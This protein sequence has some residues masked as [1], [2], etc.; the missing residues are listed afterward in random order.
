MSAERIM[1]DSATPAAVI[2]AVK[3]G[4]KFDGLPISLA[5]LY[6]DGLYAASAADWAALQAAGIDPRSLVGITVFG[7]GGEAMRAATGDAEPGDMDPAHVA[8]WALAEHKAGHYPVPYC[9]RSWKPKV[10]AACAAA[11]LTLGPGYGLWVATLDGTFTD[12]DG[13]DLRTQH[14]VVAIQYLGAKAAGI[15]ADVSLVVAPWWRAPKPPPP[16]VKTEEAYLVPT[17]PPGVPYK[18][19]RPAGT[20]AWT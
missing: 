3:A 7:T 10:I 12:L 19:T 2:E 4:R 16:P 11:G 9:D 5:A 18:V 1:L 20:K 8:A 17:D 15:N 14:G 6:L 13:T